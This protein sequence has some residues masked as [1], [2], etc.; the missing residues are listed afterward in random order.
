M[1]LEELRCHGAQSSTVLLALAG[2]VYDVTGSEYYAEGGG[3]SFF[4]GHDIT[5][6]LSCMSLQAEDLDDLTFVPQQP[7]DY[8]AL[9]GFH[10]LYHQQYPV[11]AKLQGAAYVFTDTPPNQAK[12]EEARIMSRL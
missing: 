12:D 4:A 11:V 10:D 9:K 1:T 2:F 5:K 7:E 6:C 8:Q 3:Y